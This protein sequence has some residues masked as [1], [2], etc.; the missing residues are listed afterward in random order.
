MAGARGGYTSICSMPN[1]NPTPDCFENLKLQLDVIKKDAVIN[2][3]PYGTITKG[4][5]GKELANFEEM[6]DFVIAFSDDGKGV[7][8]EEMMLK[9]M[10][11]AKKLNK[12]IVAHCE[13]NSLLNGG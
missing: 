13:E 12:K 5:N 11:N 3:Y 2:V 9:A 4:E 1:L 7:Q 6:K 10:E 8:N